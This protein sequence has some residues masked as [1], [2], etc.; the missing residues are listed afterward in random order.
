MPG[1]A[2]L[3]Y[4]ARSLTRAPAATFALVLTIA[5]GIG[6]N[7]VVVGFVRGLLTR[8]LPLPQPES[9]VSLFGRDERGEL[10]PLSAEAF[11]S[12]TTAHGDAFARLG[13]ARESQ[14]TVLIGG[15][16]MV[17]ATASVTSGLAEILDL[18][19]PNGIVLSHRLTQMELGEDGDPAG[20]GI[21]IG[22]VAG[23]V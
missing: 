22:T 23:T 7:A 15:R 14:E 2:D 5:V 19:R 21:R 1:W 20:T 4:S 10:G 11:E 13:A 12:L 16:S 17:A 3:K 18:P 8:D 6:S 9:I